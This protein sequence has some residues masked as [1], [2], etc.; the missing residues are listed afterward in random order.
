VGAHT[1]VPGRKPER[2]RERE[3][4]RER[5][6]EMFRANDL[7]GNKLIGHADADALF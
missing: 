2:E 4:E 6:R 5:G 3:G 7:P 1:V